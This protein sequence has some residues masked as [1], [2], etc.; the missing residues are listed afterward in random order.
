MRD[1]KTVHDCRKLYRE[2]LA[3]YSS[4]SFNKSYVKHLTDSDYGLLEDKSD[5]FLEMARKSGLQSEKDLLLVLDQEKHWTKSEEE[6]YQGLIQEIRDLADQ[7]RKLVLPEQI[8][9]LSAFIKEREDKLNLLHKERS[10]LL[11]VTA[12][13][14]SEKKQ[15]EEV[16]KISFYKDSTLKELLY[17]HDEFDEIERDELNKLFMAYASVSSPFVD[18]NIQKVSVCSFF[19]NSFRL[20]QEN[21][22]NFYGKPVSQLSIYQIRLFEHGKTNNAILEAEN[23]GP[24]EEYYKDLDNVV[25]WFDSRYQILAGKAAA[26]RNKGKK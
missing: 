11:S 12:E 2:I 17:S 21:A 9:Q 19:L 16:L 25:N 10:E 20:C 5:E 7:R 6:N 15:Q 18:R 14:F 23:Q 26:N 22:L 8:E 3:G 24:P 13:S 1:I 4:V